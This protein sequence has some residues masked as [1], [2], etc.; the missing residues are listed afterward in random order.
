MI[1]RNHHL[2][3]VTFLLLPILLLLAFASR[4]QA[5]LIM[6]NNLPEKTTYAIAYQ[7]SD[8]WRSSGWF[9]IPAGDCTQALS[10]NTSNKTFYYY[11]N[12]DRVDIQDTSTEVMCI[13]RKTFE[14]RNANMDCRQR[15]HLQARFIRIDTGKQTT[16]AAEFNCKDCSDW[17]LKPVAQ[18]IYKGMLAS[19]KRSARDGVSEPQRLQSLLFTS[20]RI[21]RMVPDKQTYFLRGAIYLEAGETEDALSDYKNALLFSTTD[22]DRAN[23]NVEIARAY[24]KAGNGN[25]AVQHIEEAGKRLA[26]TYR[27]TR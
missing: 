27:Q 10:G 11:V 12:S 17:E 4:V 9:S 25:A 13:S 24:L 19:D 3:T 5:E 15:G 14:I 18:Q 16:T 8:G 2:T 7:Q 20:S 22:Q 26:K 21:L 23:A 6:C 1:K